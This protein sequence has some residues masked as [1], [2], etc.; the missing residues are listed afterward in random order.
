MN[1]YIFV[2]YSM[3]DSNFT[4]DTLYRIKCA[5]LLYNIST[6]I[7]ILDNKNSINPQE[8]VIHKLINSKC[9]LILSYKHQLLSPWVRLE[10][11]IARLLGKKIFEW[12]PSSFLP[13]FDHKPR[14]SSAKK[15]TQQLNLVSLSTP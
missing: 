9:I 7:D 10:L 12:P 11:N 6:Y 1:E 3:R 2:S 5:L 15:T 14:N 13:H 4:V 8:N